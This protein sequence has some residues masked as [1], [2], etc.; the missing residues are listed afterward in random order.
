MTDVGHGKGASKVFRSGLQWCTVESSIPC[1]GEADW[2]VR[3]AAA[4]GKDGSDVV[5]VGFLQETYRIES[6]VGSLEEP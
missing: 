6:A 3:G 5:P 1:A 4:A 2:T